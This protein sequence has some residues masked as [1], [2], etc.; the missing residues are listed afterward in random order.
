MS[1]LLPRPDL[2]DGFDIGFGSV[3]LLGALAYLKFRLGWF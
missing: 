3:M 1:A 2:P